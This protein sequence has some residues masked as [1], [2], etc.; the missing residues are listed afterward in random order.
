MSGT[1]TTSIT[2]T[3][4]TIPWQGYTIA[5]DKSS[6]TLDDTVEVT[7]KPT[8]LTTNVFYN[9]DAVNQLP[10]FTQKLAALKAGT[11]KDRFWTA[12]IGDSTTAGEYNSGGSDV[13]TDIDATSYPAMLAKTLRDGGLRVSYDAIMG[14]KNSIGGDPRVALVGT[15]KSTL[16][17]LGGRAYQLLAAGDAVTFSPTDGQT[18]D[19]VTLLYFDY[20]GNTSLT[21]TVDDQAP[22][23]SNA[24]TGDYVATF[25]TFKFTESVFKEVTVSSTDAV[26]KAFVFLVL[27][28]STNPYLTIVNCGNEGAT[29]SGIVG[30]IDPSTYAAYNS[31]NIIQTMKFDATII[32]VGVNDMHGSADPATFIPA[33]VPT[34]QTYKAAGTDIIMAVPQPWNLSTYTSLTTTYRSTMESVCDENN[35]P[36]VD[37][38]NAFNNSVTD[39][40]VYSLHPQP[41]MYADIGTIF[42]ERLSNPSA[43][44][45]ATRKVVVTLGDGKVGG[46]FNPTTVEFD[47]G[48]NA[49]KTS[50]YSAATIGNITLT[51]TNDSTLTNGTGALAV[52]A[53]PI[54]PSKITTEL[55]SDTVT[56]GTEV[57]VTYTLDEPALVAVTLTGWSNGSG[58][59]SPASVVIPVGSTTATMNFTPST[60]E[61]ISVGSTSSVSTI[62]PSNATLTVSAPP[63]A[64]DAPTFS[65]T[66]GYGQVTVTV[67]APASD[68]GSAIT[69]YPIYVSTTEL[70]SA[71]TPVATLVEPG[72]YTVTGLTQGSVIYVS[73]GATNAIG[74]TTGVLKTTV[75]HTRS[76]VYGVPTGS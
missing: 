7:V 22:Q 60:V 47:A 56:T 1:T 2:D 23:T 57:E 49:S 65:L 8:P 32:N 55:S 74:T 46:S 16:S 53:K 17:S 61:K 21:V 50:T 42:A 35:W 54:P 34:L 33:I 72:D 39:P 12:C 69:G 75:G 20:K 28:H 25:Q 43:D 4:A 58:V 67:D 10:T 26:E 41:Q 30:P 71:S 5:T 63:T 76:Y 9:W 70:T 51:G 52:T 31:P 27:E 40:V 14:D 24:F 73:A 66:P 13:T 59:F 11:L 38:S 3:S 29:S 36:L 62:N 18:Y 68:G 19:Q 64:P 37:L 44:A 6:V 45:I 15:A 48:S